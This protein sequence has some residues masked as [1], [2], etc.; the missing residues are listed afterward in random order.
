MDPRSQ[1]LSGNALKGKYFIRKVI[2]KPRGLP[3]S[4]STGPGE[5]DALR[6][7]I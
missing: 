5:Q 6:F 3:L 1:A 7:E 4:P 2:A